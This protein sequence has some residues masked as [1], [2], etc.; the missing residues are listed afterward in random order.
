MLTCMVSSLYAG[1]TEVLSLL[2][3]ETDDSLQISNSLIRIDARVRDKKGNPVEGLK[4]R[5][6]KFTRTVGNRQ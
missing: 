6:S 5:I 1:G 3:Q 4:R 2:E